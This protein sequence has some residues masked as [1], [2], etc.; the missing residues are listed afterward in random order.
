MSMDCTSPQSSEVVGDTN[1][2]DPASDGFENHFDGKF[3]LNEVENAVEFVGGNTFYWGVRPKD[4]SMA[5]LYNIIYLFVEGEKPDGV[6]DDVG[7][8]ES[9]DTDKFVDEEGVVV[10][11]NG[12]DGNGEISDDDDLDNVSFDSD[13]EDDE[14]TK[15]IRN[16]K[17][18]MDFATNIKHV[19]K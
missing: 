15:L 5:D 3:S 19:L 16:A 12:D 7:A 4:M 11:F 14:R 9:K 2:F 13:E 8:V 10:G 1:G 18:F 17:R 6:V